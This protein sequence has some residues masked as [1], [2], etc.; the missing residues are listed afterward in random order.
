[1]DKGSGDL[2]EKLDFSRKYLSSQDSV[3]RRLF[4]TL[5]PTCLTLVLRFMRN[6]TPDC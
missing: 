4:S 5:L 6:M 1:M 3:F 2:I